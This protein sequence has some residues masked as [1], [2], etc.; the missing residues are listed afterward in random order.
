[1]G[2]IISLI[3]ENYSF[4][5]DEI[6]N[7]GVAAFVLGFMF[8]FR[9]WGIERFD[10]LYGLRN[11]VSSI[12]IVTLVL[13]FYLSAEKIVALIKGYKVEFNIWLYGIII[14]LIVTFVSRGYLVLAFAG[15]MMLYQVS[16]M[17]L[18]KFR[19]AWS[20][21]DLSY[22][23]LIG[24]SSALLLAILFKFLMLAPLQTLL[25][26]KALLISIM[27]AFWNMLPIPPLNG[28]NIFFHS[29]T[30]WFFSFVGIVVA[31]AFLYFYTSIL[32]ALI[33]A[34]IVGLIAATLWFIYIEKRF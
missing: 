25:L 4:S 24:P 6:K 23:S 9:E 16:G 30:I 7:I 29:R 27:I 1:M 21:K 32:L 28:S 17:R 31:S 34:V 15:S 11:L 18:G 14:A 33:S 3:K 19:Y 22:I 10:L 12:L 5:A 20:Y 13:L 8:S 26:K 2:A